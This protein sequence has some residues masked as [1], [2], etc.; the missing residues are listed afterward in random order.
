MR[1]GSLLGKF[2]TLPAGAVSSTARHDAESTACTLRTF[3][4][5]V[6][7]STGS[8]ALFDLEAK[9]HGWFDDIDALASALEALEGVPNVYF[10]T[11]AFREQGTKFGGRTAANVQALRSLR[12]DIDAGP[13]K[14]YPTRDAALSAVDTFNAAAGLHP[15]YMVSSGNGVHVYYCLQQPVP[16]AEWLT[17]AQ[18]LGSAASTLGLCADP[19]VTTDTARILR[20]P[21]S[22]NAKSGTRAEVVRVDR[23]SIMSLGNVRA[24][25]SRFASGSGAQSAAHSVD[26]SGVGRYDMAVNSDVFGTL[27]PAN[28]APIQAGCAAVAKAAH[29]AGAAT[30]EPLWRALLGI[31]KH[32]EGAEELAHSVSRGHPG[33]SAEET[34]RKLMGW[35]AGPTTCAEFERNCASECGACSHRGSIRSPIRLGQPVPEHDAASAPR[36]VQRPIDAAIHEVNQDHFYAPSESG[37]PAIWH[38]TTDERG[39]FRLVRLSQTDFGLKFA[40]RS[41][42]VDTPGGV[43]RVGLAPAWTQ[44]PARREYPGGLTLRPNETLPAGRYNLWRGF[45]VEPEAG[46]AAP[47]Q[48]HVEML[49]STAGESVADYV[50]NWL[51]FCVQRPGERPETALVL[52]GGRGTGKGT[53]LRVMAELFG[54]HGLHITQPRHLVGNFNAHLRGALFLFV[55]EGFWGGSREGEGV[56]KALVTEPSVMIEPKG[57]DPFSAPNRLKIAMA[58]NAQFVVPA[59]ADE[60]R[61]CV[62]DVPSTVAQDHDYFGP[63]NTWLD[64]GGRGIWLHFLLGRDLAG[65]NPRKAPATAA[66]SAQK[67]ESMSTLDRWILDALETGAAL[68]SRGA[69]EWPA[70]LSQVLCTAAVDEFDEYRRRGRAGQ[71]HPVGSRQLGRRLGQ[72]FGCG[73]ARMG[74]RGRCWC[75][76]GLEDARLKASQAFGLSGYVWGET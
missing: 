40:N 45:A 41:V 30:P 51:A 13:G 21:G 56:L 31:V 68:G 75:L 29:D 4:E 55:D 18:L 49:C 48:R 58:S 3:L 10:A 44:S 19:S 69:T 37:A 76:P 12:L 54:S 65:F 53:L 67:I 26:H 7:P 22:L 27:G 66:L 72:V 24:A 47:M 2:A 57:E 11:A 8:F 28:F 71:W 35:H 25:L 50:L 15:T 63:L 43:K 38:E 20:H 6:L 23:G 64:E 17:V 5:D 32:C 14:P 61:W 42:S 9:R 46:D 59:G 1:K 74:A 16:P 60:R 70:E 33:Y 34:D 36:S 73:A 52:R 62:I 39:L